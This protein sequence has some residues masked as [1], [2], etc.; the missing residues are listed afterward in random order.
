MVCVAG[1]SDGGHPGSG[2]VA[3]QRARFI[4][5]LPQ[6]MVWTS[7]LVLLVT[8]PIG[9]VVFPRGRA[10]YVFGTS[11]VILAVALGLAVAFN[12]GRSSGLALKDSN[13]YRWLAV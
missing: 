5:G 1:V 3:P 12:G 13:H 7:L 9:S 11:V 2:V 8:I 4:C 10:V 6:R